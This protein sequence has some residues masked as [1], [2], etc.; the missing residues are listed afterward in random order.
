[1][2]S[3]AYD[4]CLKEMFRLHRF[5]VKLEMDTIRHMLEG[6]GNPH[7]AYRCIHIA[8]TNGKGS[9]AA[10]LSHIFQAAGIKVGRYT[11]PHL[12]RFNERICIDNT[13]IED[14]EVVN[15]Y[16]RVTALAPPQRHPTFFEFTTAM[17]LYEFARQK[18]QWAIIE[19]GMGGRMDA[20]NMI[21]PEISIITNISLEH[22]DYLGRT[23]TAIAGEKAGII[24]P[25]T[26]IISG[27]GQKTAWDTIKKTA[28]LLKAPLYRL[29]TDF[30][31]RR[32]KGQ[33]FTF[34]GLE[35][36]WRQLPL[37]LLGD[38]QFGNAGLALAACELLQI[39]DRAPLNEA[40]IRAGLAQVTWPG[41]L[42]MV[43]S[44]PLII[45]DGAHN[46]M[47]ARLLAK[48]L[49]QNLNSYRTTLIIGILDDKP[50]RQ[51]L[52]DLAPCCERMII[53]QPVIERAIQAEILAEEALKSGRKVEIISNVGQAVQ[54]ALHTIG[55][56][57]A[58]CIAG[59]L[60]VVGEAKAALAEL[61][62][63]RTK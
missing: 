46:L 39:G 59:S 56:K 54:H 58:I 15:A 8:G 24:K 40:A 52:K 13:P 16:E 38:H 49:K 63:D 30:S 4:R 47:A 37:N 51:I 10:V 25:R 14:N 61:S 7:L 34:K 3:M 18:V 57:D 2:T 32:Q 53:T 29:G 43:S 44:S 26:P 36:T 9:V 23:I 35:T 60:Y 5:G 41:R 62:S 20:T 11:S 27:V 33:L 6:L 21:H 1:M 31:V 55:V 42:E 48:F 12:E 17:A 45:L 22:K 28:A 50:Y 19:T